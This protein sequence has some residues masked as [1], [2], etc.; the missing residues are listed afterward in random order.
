MITPTSS[1]DLLRGSTVFGNLPDVELLRVATSMRLEQYGA[2][3]RI[4]AEGERGDTAYLIASGE[5]GVI[6]RDLI[7]EEV[8]LRVFKRGDVFGEVAL[9]EDSPRTATVKALTDVDVLVLDRATFDALEQ[10]NQAFSKAIREHVDL[11]SID[12][13]LKKA[14]PFAR[15]PQDVI[16]R[17]AQ[18]LVSIPVKA[19]DVVVQ[20]GEEGDR[21]YV[22]RA[23][24]FSV[25][26]QGR[27][28]AKLGSGD[29]FG[30]IALL[31]G[32]PRIASVTA[33][34]AGE[35]LALSKA[36]FDAV[37][38]QQATFARQLT[39]LGRIRFRATTGQNLLLPDP[40]TTLMPYLQTKSRDRY[41]QIMAGS[42]AAFAASAFAFFVLNWGWAMVTTLML[43]SF[44]VP[45]MYVVYMAESD[46]LATRPRALAQI[47]IMSA[48]AGIPIS[49]GIQMLLNVDWYSFGGAVTIAAIEE[50]I[51]VIAVIWFLRRST[52][53]F[54]M[55]GLVFG[56][57]AGMGFA[58][59]ET[60][61]FGM[62]YVNAPR[63]LVEALAVRSVLAPLGH[64]TWTA[65][66]C[67]V[68][69]GQNTRGRLTD[70]RVL[71]AFALTIG[72]H[73]LWDW[74]PLSSLVQQDGIEYFAWYTNLPWFL[75]IGIVGVLAL[76]F[77]VNRAAQEEVESVV[78]LNPE[79]VL[80]RGGRTSAR[81][82]KCQRC[83]QV[84]PAG[85]HYC[86]RCGAVLRVEPATTTPTAPTTPTSVTA[87]G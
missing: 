31:T 35:V 75:A 24:T 76:R 28:V 65:I 15:V 50:P 33:L 84:A 48:I 14:S 41:W 32:G 86:V 40:L 62:G 27:E 5:A 53:R 37:L 78:A 39:E 51:K 82:V 63:V 79:L 68:I 7:G 72:L 23:G 34:E 46:I 4:I 20:E 13:F 19:G 18:Q 77:L 21:F 56:A 71:G 80:Q 2:G 55:D 38:K 36:D 11:L 64:G 52:N 3:E 87:A 9:V 61:L 42:I 67:G 29:V 83:E 30:E 81:G 47:F 54:R 17:V 58:A 44:I 1:T 26:E 25:T 70:P 66:T 59:F 8:T 45:I 22:I 10:D 12:R 69:W 16:H 60:L 57:A 6:T 74:Q 85:A 49:A 43:G 73:A